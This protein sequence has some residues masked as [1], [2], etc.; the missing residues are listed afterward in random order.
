[1]LSTIIAAENNLDALLPA[2]RL[3][4]SPSAELLEASRY[5]SQVVWDEAV[6]VGPMLLTAGQVNHGVELAE[7][8]VFICGVHRSGTTLVK[9]LLDGHPE[10]VVLP[11]EGTWYTNIEHKFNQFPEQDRAAF[12]GL[13]WLR[14]IVNPI[15]QPP[16]WLLGRST[17]SRSPYVDF[18][19]YFM[20]WYSKVDKRNPQ[21]PHT[22]V[23]L[24][25]A[26]VAGRL[27]AKLWVDKTPVNE[28]FLERIWKEMPGA[29]I[30]QVIREPS[31]ILTSRKKMEPGLNIR[32]VLH[33]LRLSYRVALQENKKND[34]R[35]L[36]L[37]YEEICA[38][39]ETAAKQIT[40]LLAI[41]NS[42]SL[43]VP[44]VGGRPAYANSSFKNKPAPGKIL[45]ADQHQ[46]ENLLTQTER[47]LL[48]AYVGSLAAKLN[49]KVKAITPARKIYH[50]AKCFFL[51]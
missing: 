30:I 32:S 46:Q 21:W 1:M 45:T 43:N 36:L 3:V 48:S 15:N 41:S 44:T 26:S 35:F 50:R 47:N 9:D 4:A 13:E 10:L 51:S 49:Y 17:D 29:K 39:A 14:R 16:Y 18:A 31:A 33:D 6:R 37:R 8:P 28:R 23:I 20:A 11:S 25:Y 12:L 38:N 27:T 22:A 19:R 2:E 40:G 34:M 24:A 7:H 5:W 42:G